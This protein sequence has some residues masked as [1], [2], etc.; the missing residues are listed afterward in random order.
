MDRRQLFDRVV[1][2]LGDEH[3]IKLVCNVM[4]TKLMTLD[5]D[6]TVRRL[7]AIAE[8]FLATVSIKLKENSVKQEVEK[9][10]ESIKDVLRATVRL[11]SKFPTATLAKLNSSNANQNW[12][13]FLEWVGKELPQQFTS[14]ET[15]VK[16]TDL[17]L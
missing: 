10:E 17:S 1:E 16:R 2:G 5:P 11:I 6:E 3:E 8:K 12:N 4:L 7:D 15:E 14:A 9:K 13:N